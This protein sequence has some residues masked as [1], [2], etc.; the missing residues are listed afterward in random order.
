MKYVYAR[1]A[2]I[3][4]VNGHP[5]TVKLGETRHADDPVV[6]AHPD[7]FSDEPI[8]VTRYPGWEPDVEQATAAPGEKR[9]VRRGN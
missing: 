1:A 3:C 2:V 5:V 9:S 8:I 4:R 7:V 6:L